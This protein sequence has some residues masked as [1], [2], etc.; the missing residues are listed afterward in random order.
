LT[1]AAP[2]LGLENQYQSILIVELIHDEVCR[3]VQVD[4]VDVKYQA[5]NGFEN[6]VPELSI[7]RPGQ[8]ICVRSLL[9]VYSIFTAPK[10]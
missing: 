9:H 10:Y 7:S 5:K 6:K 4:L 8:T 2:D 3:K 1:P